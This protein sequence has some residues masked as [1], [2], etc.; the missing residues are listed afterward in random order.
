M[1]LETWL[2]LLPAAVVLI[3]SFATKRVI[4]SLVAGILV[5]ISIM[6][7]QTPLEGLFYLSEVVYYD[8]FNQ[9]HLFIIFL[10]AKDNINTTAA[11]SKVSHVSK[12][13]LS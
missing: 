8:F 9:E 2:T 13:I 7:W 3:L 12:G 1:P 4:P 11:G 5:G 10:V 6:N